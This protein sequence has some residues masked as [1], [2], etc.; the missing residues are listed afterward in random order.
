MTRFFPFSKA[1]AAVCLA[2][3]VGV[4]GFQALHPKVA[5]AAGCSA[6]SISGPYSYRLNGSYYDPAGNYYLFAQTGVLTPDGNG[7]LAGVESQS[8]D[9]T[10]SR[11]QT[12]SGTYTVNA[13][14]TGSA[15]INT[16]LNSFV[17]DFAIYNTG[18]AMQIVDVDFN[19]IV[20]G[21]AETQ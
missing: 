3:L 19:Y 6:S 15:T 20:T 10:I 13:N 9:G 7:N 2:A 18:K 17:W 12:L 8:D 5:R 16:S 21:V 14:C 1:L 11:S 4:A